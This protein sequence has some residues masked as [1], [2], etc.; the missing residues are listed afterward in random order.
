MVVQQ[1]LEDVVDKPFPMLMQAAVLEPWEMVNS[2]FESPLPSQ[3]HP[4]AASAH[5]ANGR[6]IPGGWHTYPEMGSGASMWATPSDLARFAIGV[7]AAYNG[8]SDNVLSHETAVQM[9][10]PQ[11]AERGLGPVILDDGGDRFYF[12]HPGANDGYKSYLIAYPQRGQGVVIMTNSDGGEALYREI[13]HSVSAEYGWLPNN[14]TVYIG[15]T[16]VILLAFAGILLLR[17]RRTK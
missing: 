16:L 3:L 11:L 5:R 6:F 15:G 2:T 9:L 4:R 1:L 14:T 12:L 7:M 17:R 13:L 8:R 10:T